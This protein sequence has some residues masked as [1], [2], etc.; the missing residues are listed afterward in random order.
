[1]VMVTVMMKIVTAATMTAQRSSI[2]IP[3]HM[4]MHTPAAPLPQ[5]LHVVRYRFPLVKTARL[6]LLL[7]LQH[8]SH[9]HR[10]CKS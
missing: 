9:S 5:E 8:L 6:H 2:P 7:D 10:I 4:R 1:M 3:Q